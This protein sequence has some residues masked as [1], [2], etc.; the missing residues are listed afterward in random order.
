M[1]DWFILLTFLVAII[2]LVLMIARLKIH[3]VFTLFVVVAVMAL[4]FGTGGE[5]T[6]ELINE[7]FGDTMASVGILVIFGC[8]L[9]KMLEASGA[10]LRITQAA[11][12]ILGSR[13]KLPWG[14]ALASTVIGIP[15]IADTVVIMLIPIVSAMAVRSKETM[16][17]LGPILYIGAYVSTSLIVP[18]PGPLAAAGVLEVNI[19]ETILWGSVVTAF[20]VSA[21]TLY[22][23]TIKTYVPPKHEF[24]A[25]IVQADQ[26]DQVGEEASGS[27][28]RGATN[29]GETVVSPYTGQ[30]LSLGLS[31][32]PII[33]PIA[34]IMV[35]SVVT[36]FLAE[37]DIIREVLGFLGAPTVALA[38][39]LVSGLPL[40]G[41]H[42]KTKE[43][44][45][46]LFSEGLK[47]AA[48][49]LALTGT[50]G[51]LAL[52]VRNT[53]VAERLAEDIERTG[54]P[55]LVIPFLVGA[56]LNTITGSN[57]LGMLT[58]A[59]IMAPLVDVLGVSALAVFLACGSG[60]QV[61]KHANS[62]GFWVTTTLS[63]LTVGQG[64]RSAGVATII[65]G[66]TCFAV[67][68]GLYYT[69]II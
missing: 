43:V 2:V 13:K 14:I 31:I 59:A 33:L 28:S 21:A 30:S 1:S 62:S 45:N 8:V 20:G 63:N 17:K 65:S 3:P 26:A 50:G 61:M 46:D 40:F 34:L 32:T 47:T 22:L 4:L 39:G 24:V 6:A 29:D 56:A 10:A 64:I 69:G 41:A 19:G 15:L 36:P 49:P 35:A 52:L 42:W 66:F 27:K 38:I 23:T 57:I 53:E 67:T 60:A 68:C 9:G 48:L 7:G 18:G 51:A 11:E 44:V 55:A 16:M 58:S 25:S 5:A 12:R 54:F 37:G